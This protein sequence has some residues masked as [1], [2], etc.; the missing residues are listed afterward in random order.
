MTPAPTNK[1]KKNYTA[2]ETHVSELAI[3]SASIVPSILVLERSIS[4][5]LTEIKTLTA[6]FTAENFN[7]RTNRRSN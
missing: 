6:H 1:S 4:E 5:G 2:S 7:S 3:V